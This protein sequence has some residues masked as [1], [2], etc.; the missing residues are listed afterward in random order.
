MW[1]EESGILGCNKQANQPF[2]QCNSQ[3]YEIGDRRMGIGIEIGIAIAAVSRSKFGLHLVLKFG[4]RLT[5]RHT[6]THTDTLRQ[7]RY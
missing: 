5:Q 4:L 1:E 2:G 6:H 3:S 7:H